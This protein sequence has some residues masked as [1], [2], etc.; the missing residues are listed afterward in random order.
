MGKTT[1]A[2]S[3][4]SVQGWPTDQKAAAAIVPAATPAARAAR[5]MECT[6]ALTS[7]VGRA[8]QRAEL[9]A[10]RARRSGNSLTAASS[11]PYGGA[12]SIAGREP[13]RSRSLFPATVGLAALASAWIPTRP[14]PFALGGDAEM[15]LHPLLTDAFRQPRVGRLP[16]WTTGRWGGSPPPFAPSRATSWPPTST[17][18]IRPAV[19]HRAA[20]A[21]GGSPPVRAG[22]RGDLRASRSPQLRRPAGRGPPS[23]PAGDRL[24]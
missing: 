6:G 23:R 12:V 17:M 13:T 8:P 10:L 3:R 22:R 5:K 14:S 24:P 7:E 2:L 21:R 16:L 1:T 9:G 20:A 4:R 19:G 18:R 11:A 15:L